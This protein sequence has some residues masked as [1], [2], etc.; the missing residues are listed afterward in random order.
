MKPLHEIITII[1]DVTGVDL[2]EN[3]SRKREVVDARKIYCHLAKQLNIYSL[4]EIGEPL[5]LE[6]ATVIYHIKECNNL[7][8]TDP[9]F[10]QTS[11]KIEQ[12]CRIILS[13][14]NQLEILKKKHLYHVAKANI[15]SDKIKNWKS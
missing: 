4:K 3:K 9:M 12:E 11:D 7:I 1:K 14:L 5:G 2:I 8:K 15:L 6:H 13:K 10:Y